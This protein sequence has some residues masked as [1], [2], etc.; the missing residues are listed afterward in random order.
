MV[1]FEKVEKRSLIGCQLLV[2]IYIM[3][4]CSLPQPTVYDFDIPKEVPLFEQP[5]YNVATTEGVALGRKLFYDP[6]LS[7]N[8]TISCA[9]C[10]LQQLAFSDGISLR[11]ETP[12]GNR[13]ER[14][15]PALINL[16]W[17]DK[18]FWDGGVP[19][20]EFLATAP[21][22]HPDEMDQD[23][24]ELNQELNADAEYSKLFKDVMGTD[25]I[26]SSHVSHA[27]AQ[28]VRSLTSFNSRFD[29]FQAGEGASLTAKELKGY[30]LYKQHC[31][32][33]HTEGLFTDNGFHNNGLDSVFEN[34]T[35]FGIV[36]GRFRVTLDSNDIGKFK[37]PTLRN[38]ALTGPYMHDGRFKTLKEVLGHYRYDIKKSSTTDDFLLRDLE[39]LTR[40]TD[41]QEDALIAFLETLSDSTFIHNPIHSNDKY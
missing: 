27:L 12:S 5:D 35:L 24:M 26:E 10:H 13:L 18:L 22:Q 32:Q 11:S 40:L 1:S 3:S 20:L 36:K 29:Q 7:G 2:F 37:T 16:G 17:A 15:V 25:S 9:T 8:N 30:E 33:C 21:I 23:L 38:V 34:D 31:A 28:F 19:N 41:N 6:I 4:G 39:K 14:H